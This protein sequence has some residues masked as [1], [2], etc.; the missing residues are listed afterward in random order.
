MHQLLLYPQAK[1]LFERAVKASP[2]DALTRADYG[3]F[4]AL[5]EKDFKGA[6]ENLRE[7]IRCDPSW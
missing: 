1:R 2:E 7:A 3:R 6:L 5:V 4:L